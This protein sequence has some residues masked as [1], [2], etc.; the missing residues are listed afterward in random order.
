[1]KDIE[2]GVFDAVPKIFSRLPLSD[3]VRNLLLLLFW[4]L[5]VAAVFLGSFFSSSICPR[6][7]SFSLQRRGFNGCSCWIYFWS[8]LFI[9]SP[10]DII[11]QTVTSSILPFESN[12]SVSTP[13]HL[14]TKWMSG[15]WTHECPCCTE[16]SETSCSFSWLHCTIEIS[17][18]TSL[19]LLLLLH[20]LL[21]WKWN[22][23]IV[24][25]WERIHPQQRERTN[26]RRLKDTWDQLFSVTKLN[27]ER[28]ICR[29]FVRNSQSL[30]FPKDL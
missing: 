24:V 29:F 22:W 16:F 21:L 27:S 28:D 15:F 18:V 1:M 2:L 3:K 26:W 4:W 17:R 11:L 8:I 12:K 13:V 14:W 5:A 10:S 9:E 23:M 20:P 6:E 30:W 19:H 25:G 7:L